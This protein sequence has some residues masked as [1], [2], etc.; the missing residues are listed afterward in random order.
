MLR[1]PL[2]RL[3]PLEIQSGVEG[4][5]TQGTSEVGGTGS[6]KDATDQEEDVVVAARPRRVAAMRARDQIKAWTT[7]ENEHV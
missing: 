6:L 1:R 2:Q 4:E 5:G 7:Y 3:Y